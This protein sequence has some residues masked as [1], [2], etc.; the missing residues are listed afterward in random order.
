MKRRYGKQ[1]RLAS[2]FQM[3]LLVAATGINHSGKACERFMGTV[4]VDPVTGQEMVNGKFT[5]AFNGRSQLLMDTYEKLLKAAHGF[6]MAH[7]YRHAFWDLVEGSQKLENAEQLSVN[8][9]VDLAITLKLIYA[10]PS[11]PSLL[12][13]SQILCRNNELDVL[14]AHALLLRGDMIKCTESLLNM[15]DGYLRVYAYA[16]EWR[17]IGYIKEELY[18]YMQNVFFD[19]PKSNLSH[20]VRTACPSLQ[21]QPFEQCYSYL[22]I[23]NE[24][25][26]VLI[27]HAIKQTEKAKYRLRLSLFFVDMS[28]LIADLDFVYGMRDSHDFQNKSGL[29]ALLAATGNGIRLQTGKGQISVSNSSRTLPKGNLSNWA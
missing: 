24:L 11:K 20:I 22:V 3:R 29:L 14:A 28:E 17:S 25:T 8:R 2:Q 6:G 19:D 15:L 13:V 23:L 12:K 27:S 9:I 18:Y 5:R 26:N 21:S 4:R 7:V 16:M 1:Y 10:S